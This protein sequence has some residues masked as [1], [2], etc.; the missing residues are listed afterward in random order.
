M[1]GGWQAASACVCGCPVR[2]AHG[3]GQ[4]QCVG[5]GQQQQ[6]AMCICMCPVKPVCNLKAEAVSRPALRYWALPRTQSYCARLLLGPAF[7]YWVCAILQNGAQIPTCFTWS[8]STPKELY[9]PIQHHLGHPRT[10]SISGTTSESQTKYAS[11]RR[12]VVLPH[13][14][15]SGYSLQAPA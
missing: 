1:C 12:M 10:F 11:I 14:A 2:P 5:Y 3:G 7:G 8:Y 4:Q 13:W 6:H 9:H 15:S